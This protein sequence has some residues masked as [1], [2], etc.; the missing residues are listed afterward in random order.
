MAS[1]PASAE[2]ARSLVTLGYLNAV[3]VAS[4]VKVTRAVTRFQRHAARKYRMPQPDAGGGELFAG[5]INGESDPL[6]LAEVRKWIAR[7]WQIPIGR[8]RVR[9]LNVATN[10]VSLREDAAAA[11]EQIVKAADAQGATLGGLYGD[12]ARPVRPTAK[13][14]SSRYSF[15]YCGRAVDICQDFTKSKDHRYYVAQDTQ[16]P[17]QYWRIHCKTDK[18]DG[19]QGALIR[20]KTV[21]WYSFQEKVERWL[22]EGRYVDLTAL[23]ESTGTFERIKAQSGWQSAYNKAE[24]WHFQYKLDKQATFLDEMELIGYS[25]DRLRSCGWNSDQMLDHAPG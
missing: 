3:D 2:I 19:S 4:A 8:F 7:K 16:G 24:W 1:D 15:H 25:E 11:W 21:K 12:S 17:T 6:T 9:S 20:E 5:R 10:P 18:Q 13:V 22:P 23:I 14:G